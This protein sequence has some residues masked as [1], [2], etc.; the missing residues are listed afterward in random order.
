MDEVEKFVSFMAAYELKKKS[1]DDIY[2]VIGVTR[3]CEFEVTL[4][5][6]HRIDKFSNNI[7]VLDYNERNHTTQEN[8]SLLH[9]EG[10]KRLHSSI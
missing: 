2:E 4:I 7:Y 3:D 10:N 9:K 6:D 8:T 5:L 1:L